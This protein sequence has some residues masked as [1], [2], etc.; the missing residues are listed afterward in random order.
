ML[1]KVGEIDEKVNQVISDSTLPEE[2]KQ[3]ATKRWHDLT[4]KYMKPTEVEEEKKK[5]STIESHN[6]DKLFYKK[7]QVERLKSKKSQNDPEET[8]D[9][10][11]GAASKAA[12]SSALKPQHGHG[13]RKD[14]QREGTPA[15]PS[16]VMT[17]SP[18]VE[19]VVAED[20]VVPKEG[21]NFINMSLL[22]PIEV[23]EDPQQQQKNLDGEELRRSARISLTSHAKT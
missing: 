7:H 16:S 14:T 1:N 9:T 17:Q 18:G 5:I 13:E 6:K 11:R 21:E 23:H 20:L 8:R 12:T 4:K 10:R 22:E 15:V 19:P 3:M 2:V